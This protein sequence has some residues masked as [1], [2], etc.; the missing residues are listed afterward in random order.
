MIL[1]SK[2]ERNMRVE[3][4]MSC[5]DRKEVLGVSTCGLCGCPIALKTKPKNNYCDIGKWAAEQRK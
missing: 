4:C 1:A 3:I 2:Q 5:E